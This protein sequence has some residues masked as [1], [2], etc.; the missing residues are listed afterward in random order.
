MS[1]LNIK[2]ELEA[3]NKQLKITHEQL[4]PQAEKAL[5]EARRHGEVSTKTKNAADKALTLANALEVKQNALEAQLGD[6]EQL[7][8]RNENNSGR[9]S[10]K[11]IGQT[12]ASFEG[13]AEFAKNLQHGDKLRIPIQDALTTADV[14]GVIEPMRLPGIDQQPKQRLF[15]RDLIAP[16]TTESNALFWVQQTGFTNAAAIVPE[17]TKKPYS[18]IAFATKMTQVGTIA[19]MFKASKQILDDMSQLMSTIDAEMRFGLKQE[20]ERQLLFGN[21]TGS[22]L[23]GIVPQATAFSSPFDPE[24]PVTNIDIVRLAMLQ[25]RLARLPATATVMDFLEWAK[26]ELTKNSLGNYIMANPMNLVGNTLWSLPVVDTDE[27][28]FRGKFLTG[29]FASA[30]QIFDREEA[31]VIISTENDTDFEDNMVSIR[32]EERLGLVVKRPESFI[33]GDFAAAKTL[34]NA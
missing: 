18:D 1:D 11:T 19:H 25:A 6:A 3:V 7:F 28:D 12:V 32:C 22:N 17:G 34:L 23:T 9:P 15:I 14:P 13:L 2:A 33:F 10:A 27:P 21:G 24:A 8:K 26:I 20:E 16:G 29:A 4:L 5:E 31:N 30:A